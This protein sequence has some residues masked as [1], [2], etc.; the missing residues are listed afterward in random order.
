[1]YLDVNPEPVRE[2]AGK[3][4][5]PEQFTFSKYFKTH[6]GMSPCSPAD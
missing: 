6:D 5:F 4:G 1:M 2:I 3:L